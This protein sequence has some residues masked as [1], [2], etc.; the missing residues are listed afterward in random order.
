MRPSDQE[1]TPHFANGFANEPLGTGRYQE[2]HADIVIPQLANQTT[3][4]VIGRHLPTRESSNSKTVVRG[5]GT[6]GSNPPSPPAKYRQRLSGCPLRP[7]QQNIAL[8]SLPTSIAGG[9]APL[10]CRTSGTNLLAEFSTRH[11][12]EHNQDVTRSQ[13]L[14]MKE[15]GVG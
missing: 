11:R 7:R 3:R 2:S 5:N 6:V 15:L 10:Y 8:P 4:L 14:R 1:W 13:L 9:P 12:L